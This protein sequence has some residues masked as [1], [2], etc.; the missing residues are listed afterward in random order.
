MHEHEVGLTR[1]EHE[2]LLWI[3][4]SGLA[5][6]D[7]TALLDGVCA[8][9]VAAGVPLWRVATGA[10]V[11]HPL[12][13]ARG[14]RW[15]RGQGVVRE[16]FAREE[17]E[18]ETRN[19]SWLRSPFHRLVREPECR[20]LRRSLEAGHR[21]GEFPLLDGFRAQGATD[22]LAF[23]VDTGATGVRRSGVLCSYTIDRP[24]GFRPAEI[25]LLRRVTQAMAL[26]FKAIGAAET[27]RMLARTYLGADAGARVLDGAI[28]RGL[29]ETVRAVLW[30]SDLEGFTR[31][32]DTAPSD[33]L[34]A[35]LND[36]AEAVV[37]SVQGAGGQVLKFI[38]D[39]VLAMFPLGEDTA[40][41]SRALD[42]AEELLDAVDGMGR[43]RRQAG[44][45]ATDIHVA[46]HLGEVLY[47]N[48]GSRD[49]LDFTV[50]GPAVNE[51]ARIESL[52]RSLEQ[53]VI[54]SSAF[55]AASGKAHNRL[56]SLGRYALKGVRRPEELFTLDR[57]A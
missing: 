55:A 49:R 28:A 19:E 9:L 22:Y 35:L 26:G 32:A 54:V 3:V 6:E 16:E 29:T 57:G 45:L 24:G 34:L 36:Y 38:G 47:G 43:A 18:D 52:C 14:C 5:A 1:L 48:I 30:Y 51:V 53:R 7:E 40:P 56:V 46:L 13:D 44:L 27:T 20:E 39:G 11:L 21:P 2:L 41:C 23:A 10:D 8:R 37:T 15:Q 42:A 17:L 25:G 31:I 33:A 4:A 50:V 12:L